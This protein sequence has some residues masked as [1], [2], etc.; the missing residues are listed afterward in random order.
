MKRRVIVTDQRWAPLFCRW[1]E[2]NLQE[3]GTFDPNDTRT[4]AHVELSDDG[5]FE[6][7]CVVGLNHWTTHTVEGNIASDG[8][9]RWC[10]RDF[11][12]TVYDYAFRH[13]DKSR[14]N[15]TVRPDNVDAIR[16]H[17][18]LG[19][20]FEFRLTDANGEGEDALIYG[21]T[22]SQWR[23]GRWARPSVA[24]SAAHI[25]TRTEQEEFGSVD[26]QLYRESA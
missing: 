25:N 23:S 5:S 15:F 14:M 3:P 1:L 24:R 26:E 16:M 21:L 11:C 18:K 20:Q 13:A 22:R 9:K 17:E 19:H 8:T 2:S 7:L 12:F 6:I 4:I 10:S